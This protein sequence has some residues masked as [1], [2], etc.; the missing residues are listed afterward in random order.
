M[1]HRISSP[2]WSVFAEGNG[3]GLMNGS[4][5]SKFLDEVHWSVGTFVGFP[6]IL[7]QVSDGMERV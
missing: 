3:E 4:I 7:Q 2:S 1:I 5:T 6:Q